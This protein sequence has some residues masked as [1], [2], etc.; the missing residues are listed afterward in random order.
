MMADLTEHNLLAPVRRL[1]GFQV[2]GVGSYVPELVVRNQDLVQ[3]GCDP[4]WILRRTG[5]LER[6]HSPPEMATSDLAVL[7]AERAIAQAGVSK[8]DIDLVG[9]GTFTP[10]IPMPATPCLWQS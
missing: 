2:I 5:I 9:L 7:A 3:F 4:E 6:R 8:G 1:T 10:D